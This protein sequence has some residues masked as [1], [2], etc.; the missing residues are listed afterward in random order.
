MLQPLVALLDIQ[1][2]NGSV[3][4]GQFDGSTRDGVDTR[5][6]Y[7]LPLVNSLHILRDSSL[8][9]LKSSTGNVTPR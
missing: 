2:L 3:A 9:L 8:E 5:L 4:G 1:L 6:L 7:P